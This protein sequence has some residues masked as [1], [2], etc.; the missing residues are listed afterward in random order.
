MRPEKQLL[1]DEIKEKMDQ[2]KAMILTRYER[3]NPNLAS[4]FR[5]RIG[6]SGGALEVVRKRILLKAAEAAGIKID[7]AL[8]EGHVAVVFAEQD[9]IEVTKAIYKFCKEN[10]EI[11]HVLGGRFEGVL[12]SAQ[13]VE[14][15][16]KL[17]AKD[18]M[19]AQF[20]GTLE[21]P[22]SQT[23]SVMDALLTS[24]MHCLENKSQSNESNA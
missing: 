3:L 20:L 6:K 13:D 19:R 14:Q 23:L 22:L 7:E 12:Y 2:S 5:L 24:V 8:L 15:I 4:D 11:L 16:S 1:L 17:P 9:P 18:E 10:E 21:A